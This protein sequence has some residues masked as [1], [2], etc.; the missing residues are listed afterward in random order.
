M[1]GD[2]EGQNDRGTTNLS[3]R[4]NPTEESMAVFSDGYDSHAC[5]TT[6]K[7]TNKIFLWITFIPHGMRD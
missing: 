6:N 4:R 3:Q 2:L 1:V 7:N 5:V